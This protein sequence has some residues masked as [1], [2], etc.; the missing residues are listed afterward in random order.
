[1]ASSRHHEAALLFEYDPRSQRWS[2]SQGLRDLYGLGPHEAPTTQLILDRMVQPDRQSVGGQFE[3]HLTTPGSFSCTFQ[4]CNGR[5]CLRQVRYVG[6]SEE[7]GDEVK[8][9][10]G[11]VIDVTDVWRDY[12][13]KAVEGALEHRAAI[14]QAK[15]ALMLSFGVD[16]ATAFQMLRG[17]SSRANVKLAVVAERIASGLSD[18]QFCR[19]EPVRSL[20]D[21]VLALEPVKDS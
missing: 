20:L 8:R 5:G 4:M 1:M 7:G 19:D 13:A 18:P 9:V 17:Y 16:D 6:Q 14:E 2:W 10:Y 12:A 11:F 15:G 21:I 3:D